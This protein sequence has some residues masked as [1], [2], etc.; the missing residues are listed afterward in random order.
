MQYKNNYNPYLNND[1]F[2]RQSIT[3]VTDSDS[4]ES[5]EDNFIANS[6]KLAGLV[7][8][9]G[10][11]GLYLYRTGD[12]RDYM[13]NFM[14]D[15]GT[16]KGILWAK[17][18]LE[19][20]KKVTERK[21]TNI[22]EDVVDMV[23]N[24]T[25]R[26][27]TEDGVYNRSINRT[28]ENLEIIK[29][30]KNK[31]SVAKQLEE[32]HNLSARTLNRMKDIMNSDFN[33]HVIFST[34]DAIEMERKTRWRPATVGE[35]INNNHFNVTDKSMINMNK[36]VFPD[37][38]HRVAD[39]HV[40]ISDLGE[41][42]DIR[43]SV[44]SMREMGKSLIN[45]FQIPI[46]GISV[47][48]MFH[49]QHFLDDNTPPLFNILEASSIQPTVSL[50]A[51]EMGESILFSSGR[52]WDLK[53]GALIEDNLSLVA[54][55]HGFYAHNM[56]K[57]AGV[58]VMKKEV[59]WDNPAGRFAYNTAKLLD[60]GMQDEGDFYR[61]EFKIS[62]AMTW[63]PS[64]VE[65]LREKFSPI[66]NVPVKDLKSAF[67]KDGKYLVM[68][69]T[70]KIGEQGA[71]KQLV[72][73]RND[74]ENVTKATMVPYMLMERVN[75]AL[76]TMG[77]GL[78]LSHI[79]SAGDVFVNLLSRKILPVVVGIG[80]FKYA[81][82]LTRNKD[83]ESMVDKAADTY[84][85]AS[86][87][88][89]GAKDKLGIT[90]FMKK[91]ANLSPG[92]DQL[93]ELPIIG[94]LFSTK[95]AEETDEYWKNG[96][97]AVRKGR[98]WTLGNTP[99]TG[100]R[101]E[102]FKPNWVNS[103][104]SNYQYTDVKYGSEKEYFANW[105]LPT[106]TNPLA[107]IKHFMTDPYHWENKHMKDRPYPITGGIPELREIPM[108]GPTVDST[109]G[110]IL[111]PRKKMHMEYWNGDRLEQTNA[112]ESSMYSNITT[113][114]IRLKGAPGQYAMPGKENGAR[115]IMYETSS[116]QLDIV[117]A[118]NEVSLYE[119]NKLLKHSSVTASS[120]VSKINKGDSQ[121]GP[122]QNLNL[123]PMKPRGFRESAEKTYSD[124]TEMAGFYGFSFATL[125]GDGQIS[126]PRIQSSADMTSYTRAF[127]DKEL[128]GLGGDVSEMFRRFVPKK[129]RN[130]VINELNPIRNTMPTWLPGKEYY[131]D[132]LHG[133]A[134]SKITN[135]EYR[136][137]GTGYEAM[138]H[139]DDP[140]KLQIGSSQIGHSQEDIV[141]HFLKVDDIEITQNANLKDIL[142]NGTSV[143]NKIEK[144]WG[145]KGIAVASEYKVED[146]EHGIVGWIDSI[147]VDKSSKTGY[148]IVD[149][150]T[151]SAK[152]YEKL[153]TEGGK[154][155]NIAQIN[156]YMYATG[157]DNA[158]LHYINREDPDAPTMT[159]EYHYDEKLMRETFK[160]LEEARNVVRHGISDG[161]ISRGDLYDTMD[162]FKILADV[163]PYSDNYRMYSQIMSQS[164]LT[165]EEKKDVQQ[166]RENVTE[167]KEFA[168]M[169]DYK[170]KTANLKYEN[171]KV[172]D[173]LDNGTV[174]TDKYRENPIK[175]AG[176]KFSTSKTEDPGVESM[177]Y[178]KSR[179]R[180][181]Q[182]ITIGYTDDD[183]HK[184]NRDTYKS[185]SAVVKLRGKNLN[186]EMMKRHLAEEK[187]D[188]D[189]PAGIH[190]RY[191]DGEITYGKTWESIS[192]I[193]SFFNTK[194]MQVRSP[195]E[196]Y[197][198]LD[199]YGREWQEW[200]HPVKDFLVP[201]AQKTAS[202]GFISSVAIG[203]FIGSLF[204]STKFGKIVG[205]SIG[206][207]LMATYSG[208][209]HAKSAVTKQPF[210]PERRQK[211]R[212][213]NEYMD[214]LKF[215]KNRKLFEDYREQAI[216]KEGV[217]PAK[218]IKQNKDEGAKRKDKIRYLTQIKRKIHNKE[219][220][221]T[222]AMK[223]VKLGDAKN[224]DE[225][226]DLINKKI[227]YLTNYRTV[228]EISPL[229]AQAIMY[230]NESEKT[231]YAYDKGDPLQNILSA[232][233]RRERRYLQPFIDA[234]KEERNEIIKLVP[235]YMKRAL[236][237]A[238]GMKVD[239]K[240]DLQ[241]YFRTHSLPG[242]SWAG[243]RPE[244]DLD[245]V[246][247]K[248]VKHEGMDMSEFDFW[249]DDEARAEHLDI[250]VPKINYHN[251]S[252][253]IKN[254]LSHILSE[255]GLEDVDV[256]VSVGN[257]PGINMD[258]QINNN[259]TQELQN[260]V[261]NYGVM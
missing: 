37:I 188:D 221:F 171:V 99:Y 228:Q 137:P 29:I 15:F 60:L 261:D 129:K 164:D 12:F 14:R 16:S 105:W 13:H 20:T 42:L 121:Y 88:L 167:S 133:D 114:G 177:N 204:G 152:G 185:I 3:D 72:A 209:I 86:V 47:P 50:N 232:L 108:I 225:L 90:G 33:D 78:D 8:T 39:K 130:A 56:R 70:K 176:I 248:M 49:V 220:P 165:D 46:L 87:N 192:H 45:D 82:S 62:E 83:G 140:T 150:K 183:L 144:D 224:S 180:K 235:N 199:L 51:G 71:L 145:R 255:T 153:K 194:F 101:I 134:Y 139:I 178:L 40:L 238:Y 59:R 222:K 5:R 252:R 126:T 35:L 24:E 201:A 25:I 94:K 113:P 213:L 10:G 186:K 179:L 196:M 155:E 184:V 22:L 31:H 67:G 256:Q 122:Q 158:Y 138:N 109:L 147:V 260:Y 156:F 65:K 173:V 208:G 118:D 160:N 175:L 26:Q 237:S 97:D 107:P 135:G 55:N 233:N 66:T 259:R 223:Q 181:G 85:T 92:F 21:H 117:S 125:A 166:I 212:N 236:Q 43:E 18:A 149:Y 169:Y 73:G 257:R 254:K 229:A 202:K 104:K 58:E 174:I 249:S 197:K 247:V 102:Y 100:G 205:G 168:R 91:L 27:A 198:R 250:P 48:R 17:D 245:D 215:I 80:A 163:A 132:F 96:K 227:N 217:D 151:I 191:T 143:H 251:T 206:G 131:I 9:V 243:W 7:T 193:D 244:V 44:K 110:R 79:G 189:S 154:P 95:N 207:L 23:H 52:A 218:I 111:K 253:T 41:V 74:L 103:L 93:Q 170:F 172:I 148:S 214:I 119:L 146:K 112:Q 30:L 159:F 239:D 258:V 116:G 127:W 76:Q 241:K 81:N 161:T 162:R 63:I 28:M 157:Q 11:T 106:P 142:A 75:G 36:E 61:H 187:E 69:N 89:A 231:A 115:A 98:Y 38:M 32:G 120:K 2:Y 19:A 234:P 226:L 182:T 230:Y 4:Y 203:T 1:G 6:I 200:T 195:L 57:M 128:G 136:L 141:K 124:L 216:D 34:E 246:K 77:L 84:V 64:V 123:I 240:P 53:N 210:I 68:R 190:A 211:E 242:E 54:R 219:I